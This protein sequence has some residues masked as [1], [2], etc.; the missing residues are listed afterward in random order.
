MVA[1]IANR[2]CC[3]HEVIVAAGEGDGKLF[4]MLSSRVT[5]VKC[6]HL[7]RALSPLK[8]IK[9]YMELK[10][11]YRKYRPDVVHLHSS[12]AATLGR[13]AFPRKKIVYT[14]HGFD[15]VRLA[16]RKFLP[17]ERALQHR[18]RAIVAVSNYD[19]VNLESEGINNNIVT[20]LNGLAKPSTAIT[21]QHKALFDSYSKRVLCIARLSAPKLPE[22]FIETARRLPDCG[23]I[24]I[25]NQESVESLGV[26]PTNCHFLGNIA[27]A[28]GYC[29][30][31][32]I[33]MLPSNYEGLPMVIIEAM[34]HGCPVV[35]SNVGGISEIVT[36]GENGFVV[37]NNP[38]EFA[39]KISYILADNERQRQFSLASS[40][41]YNSRLTVDRMVD[42]YL[43]L[44]NRTE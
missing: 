31:A 27:G 40:K 34:S 3:E 16:F 10:G 9:A 17:V 44:Y 1:E 30:E 13:L 19:K 21:E 7:Q 28:G 32:D 24:W 42:G 36:N 43:K 15:S 37:S 23:F 22:I 5:R 38:E 11:L 6:R 35:A 2:L 25:G 18:S 39:E 20:I 26:L 12:K 8:D 14:V 41:V 33:F 29:S 4:D